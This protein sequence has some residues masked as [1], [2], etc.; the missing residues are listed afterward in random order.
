MNR[1]RD[2][3][4]LLTSGRTGPCVFLKQVHTEPLLIRN[5]LRYGSRRHFRVCL[6]GIC[7]F[8]TASS[9][10]R[11]CFPNFL[12]FYAG[13]IMIFPNFKWWSYHGKHFSWVR[14]GPLMTNLCQNRGL[15]LFMSW[16]DLIGWISYDGASF[17]NWK[18]RLTRKER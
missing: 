1:I 18:S 13:L 14:N 4:Q 10:Y 5:Q 15:S 3:L 9:L 8:F 11:T 16:V 12:D 17:S 7:C 2:R 6:Y